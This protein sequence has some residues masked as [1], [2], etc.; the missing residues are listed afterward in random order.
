MSTDKRELFY[1]QVH[2]SRRERKHAVNAAHSVRPDDGIGVVPHVRTVFLF[3]SISFCSVATNTND[4][5]RW[6]LK[7][8]DELCLLCTHPQNPIRRWF[9]ERERMRW[10]HR[11]LHKRTTHN[12]NI[13][14][15]V[16]EQWL[17]EERYFRI[18]AKCLC[19]VVIYIQFF[20]FPVE[21]PFAAKSICRLKLFWSL[22]PVDC[23]GWA[24]QCTSHKQFNGK[25]EK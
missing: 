7:T 17:H 8:L 9:E 12:A 23:G 10:H 5:L 11:S 3:S 13:E 25:R 24:D 15:V 19:L 20:N 14:S 22:K 6:P 18:E 21:S 2:G 16:S 1:I 4:G